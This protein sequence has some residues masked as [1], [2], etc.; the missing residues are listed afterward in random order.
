MQGIVQARGW[1]PLLAHRDRRRHHVTASSSPWRCGQRSASFLE[2]LDGVVDV[3][4]R[5]VGRRD[6]V[7]ARAPHRDQALAQDRDILLALP[8]RRLEP[9]DAFHIDTAL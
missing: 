6:L 1:P 3:L 8:E 9:A 4:A 7:A 2:V 5:L